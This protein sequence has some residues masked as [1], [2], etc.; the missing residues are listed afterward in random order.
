MGGLL[1]NVK[2]HINLLRKI[3]Y[4]FNGGRGNLKFISGFVPETITI[5]NGFK[6]KKLIKRDTRCIIIYQKGFPRSLREYM[7]YKFRVLCN[8]SS[9]KIDK[10]VDKLQKEI[11]PQILHLAKA[12]R[13][14][15]HRMKHSVGAKK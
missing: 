14:K 7:P 9:Q 2:P 1:F 12:P 15:K 13:V 10:L 5:P 3:V 11:R 6:P 8:N 4:F